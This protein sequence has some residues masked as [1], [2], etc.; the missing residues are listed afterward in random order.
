MPATFSNVEQLLN[1]PLDVVM[2][3]QDQTCQGP[4]SYL[5]EIN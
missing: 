4:E 5:S 3:S 2:K 1:M